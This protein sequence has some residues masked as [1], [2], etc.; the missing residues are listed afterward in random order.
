ME[1]VI[2]QTVTILAH[3]HL[4]FFVFFLFFDLI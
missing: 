4:V 2:F 3:V 1:N